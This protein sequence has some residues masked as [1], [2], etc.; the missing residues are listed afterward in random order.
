MRY[1]EIWNLTCLIAAAFLV[2]FECLQILVKLDPATVMQLLRRDSRG[3]AGRPFLTTTRSF[4]FQNQI[5]SSLQNNF[6]CLDY[7]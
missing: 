2:S 6:N 3:A 5:C 1:F 4:A 7:L